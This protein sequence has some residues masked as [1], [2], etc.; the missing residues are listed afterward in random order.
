MKRKAFL[1]KVLAAAVAVT[2]VLPGG[3]TAAA[4]ETQLPQIET[5]TS[6][7]KVENQKDNWQT[8]FGYANVGGQQTWRLMSGLVDENN[9]GDL[10]AS[11]APAVIY[12]SDID[13]KQGEEAA[14]REMSFE[15]FP[16]K[17]T[18]KELEA[19]GE[20]VTETHQAMLGTRFGIFL[21]YV[22]ATH[23]AFLGY[24]DAWNN[25]KTQRNQHWW[26]EYNTGSATGYPDIAFKNSE[27]AATSYILQPKTYTRINVKYLSAGEIEVSLTPLD[28][29]KAEITAQKVTATIGGE[30]NETIKTMLEGLRTYANTDGAVKPIHFGFKAGTYD[31]N[32]TDMNIG[33]VKSN[34]YGTEEDGSLKPLAYAQCGWEWLKDYSNTE[35]DPPRVH[36]EPGENNPDA[37][38]YDANQP[39][40]LRGVPAGGT[41]Y[42]N[43][44][45]ESGEVTNYLTNV[46]DF[47][48]GTVSAIMRSFKGSTTGNAG[49]F[50][51]GARYTPAG[52]TNGAAKDV[53][54]GWDGSK[55]VYKI[56]ANA[57]VQ[58][59]GN[60]LPTP[61]VMSDYLV[62][63]EIDKN[64]KLTASVAAIDPKKM[65][66]DV[67]DDE[68]KALIPAAS[69]V[70][71]PSGTATG[72]IAPGS[73]SITAGAGAQLRVR[74]ISYTS[75][76]Y[77]DATELG[78]KYEEVTGAN[79]A[80]VAG[81]NADN[82]YFTEAWTTFKAAVASV[83]EVKA[84]EIITESEQ[85]AAVTTLQN[86]YTTLQQGE[87]KETGAYKALQAAYDEV[88][89]V[90]KGSYTDDTWTPFETARTEVKTIVDA[91]NAGNTPYANVEAI[92]KTTEINNLK[93][94]F[95][96]LDRVVDQT[97][98]KNK[99]EQ[100]KGDVAA[101][102]ASLTGADAS[103]YPA[104]AL[105]AYQAALTEAQTCLNN[106][107]A[108][109]ATIKQLDAALA[110]IAE[111]KTNFVPRNASAEETAAFKGEIDKI[112]AS[113]NKKY[114]ADSLK[115]YQDALAAAEKLLSDGNATK[116][117]LD[118]ALT[119]LQGAKAALKEDTG[120]GTGKPPIQN[121]GTP[122]LTPG[123]SKT[124][125]NATYKVLD[126]AKKTVELTKGDAKAKS[127]KIDKVK[128]D[129]IDCTVVSIGANA[130]KGAKNLT[131]VTIGD[132]VTSI[133]KNAF[134]GAKKLKSVVVGKAVKTI[135]ASAFSGCKKLA[136]VTF[137]GTAVSKIQS[138]AF[139][140]TSKK[141][142]VK[143]PKSLKKN[144][145]K[146][147]A[148]KK[149]LTKAGM[150]KKLKLK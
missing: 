40:F 97:A 43:L 123:A 83:D 64:N 150:S 53:R 44:D 88:K 84:K 135:G 42:A 100:L 118:E 143:I 70:D 6:E 25:E 134:A 76:S 96:N 7:K 19:R 31:G 116:K 46:S 104:E 23:W 81:D 38:G 21:K 14:V 27:G 20:E 54:V 10:T 128:I 80:N 82:K 9:H 45:G 69:G 11:N 57:A 68:K 17:E 137:K 16:N 51:L 66:V 132:S 33:D 93:S 103:H 32:Q 113:A 28:E 36:K 12:A 110:K 85:S 105:T 117:A 129:G 125:A 50:Y 98:D 24:E 87:I 72:A 61:Q 30:E 127:A 34:V 79:G 124:V 101:A 108:G 122:V 3:L 52:E 5:V 115:V 107:E 131:S 142:T 147:T 71:I 149:K 18:D 22:D 8:P 130:F 15:L 144:K 109:N 140:G 89:D 119:K 35:V 73:I 41:D 62:S 114:T 77:A 139:K 4:V 111:A 133:G 99:V 59:P 148:F 65:T 126:A 92:T 56:G 29:N 26:V 86:A 37:E 145:K 48:V 78:T 58:V 74:E 141:V 120:S 49:A 1:A 146:S 63:M 138:K 67:T 91:I 13:I 47:N 2:S 60:D 136:K 106:L 121:P 112:K 94:A 95:G 102:S 75:K 55:W 39:V 90:V